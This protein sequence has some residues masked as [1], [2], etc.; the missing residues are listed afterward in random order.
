[1]HCLIFSLAVL[2]LTFAGLFLMVGWKSEASKLAR[3]AIAMVIGSFIVS[4]LFELLRSA[5]AQRGVQLAAGGL[6]LLTLVALAVL[7]VGWFLKKKDESKEK[8][9]PTIR[10]RAELRGGEEEAPALPHPTSSATDDLNLFG[11]SP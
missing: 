5:S 7:G 1:M 11:G 3:I 6:I 10:R 9:R 4:W 8:V 2:L